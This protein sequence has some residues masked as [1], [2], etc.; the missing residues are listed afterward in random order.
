MTNRIKLLL[1]FSILFAQISFGQSIFGKWKTVDDITGK[2][3]G[4]VEIY[5]HK[6]KIYGK[7]VEIFEL[8]KKHLKC[9]KCFGEDNNKSFLG[10]IIIKGLT[11]DNEVYIGGKVLDP[12]IGKWYHCKI[13][14][15]GKDKLI[16][17]GYIGISL[18]GRSQIW[19][20][21]K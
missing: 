11:K 12:K 21:V 5:E 8:D 17:R 9:D 16:V 10:L 14:L 7:I 4:V 6:G 18:F 2:E 13:T 1:I 19:T 20:R 15:E 3:K